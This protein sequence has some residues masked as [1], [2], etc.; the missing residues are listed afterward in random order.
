MNP[1]IAENERLTAAAGEQR[2]PSDDFTESIVRLPSRR[3]DPTWEIA[4][5]Y[6]RQGEW[7]E[8]QYLAIETNR[9]IDFRDGFLEFFSV[10][11]WSHEWIQDFLHDRLKEFVRP[12]KL[13][14]TAGSG[15]KIRMRTGLIRE[16]DVKFLQYEKIP[17][18]SAPSDSADLV[19]EIV[20]P[21]HK[22]RKRDFIEK[23][24]DYEETGIPEYWIVD[25]E[26]EVIT[27]LTLLNGVYQTHG[28]FK[29]GQVATSVLLDGF[30]I[31]VAACFAAGQG[32]L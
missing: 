22:D 2:P 10:P 9:R 31:D 24:S 16:P 4:E 7:T 12:R 1:S 17:N 6:P 29:P 25:P 8:E 11:T 23:R 30:S 26:N 28:E 5:L 13:G 21:D 15:G 3:G 19:M 20:S 32:E 27:V 14:Y 18:P